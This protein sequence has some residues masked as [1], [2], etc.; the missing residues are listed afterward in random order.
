MIRALIIGSSGFIGRSL[1]RELTLN[2]VDVCGVDKGGVSNVRQGWEVDVC[3]GPRIAEVLSQ[4]Q[5]QYVFHVAGSVSNTTGNLYEESTRVLLHA[6]REKARHAVVLVLGSAAE[7]GKSTRGSMFVGESSPT[8][9]VSDYGRAKLAQSELARSLASEL[10]LNVIRVRLFNTLGPGQSTMLVAGA[11]IERLANLS[12]N[13]KEIFPVK[14]PESI[15]DFLDVRDVSRVLWQVASHWKSPESGRLINIGTGV[16]TKIQNLARD[17]IEACGE[18][19]RLAPEPQEAGPEFDVVADITL[20]KGIIGDFLIQT[21]P[22][23]T[24]L[25]DMWA[26]YMRSQQPR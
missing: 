7:Y 20:L 25:R 9:P 14:N 19:L 23:K 6:V 1:V 15:R 26:W 3:D 17:L 8:Q 2:G 21:I 4:T 24:S 11:M 16:G 13:G 18:S 12:N 5:P 10:G 22:V